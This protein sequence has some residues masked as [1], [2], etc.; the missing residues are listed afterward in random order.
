M[1]DK[2]YEYGIDKTTSAIISL[3]TKVIIVVIAVVCLYLGISY[4][5]RFGRSLLYVDPAE[6]TP[7][8]DVEI[9]ITEYDTYE[10]LAQKLYESNVITNELSFVVQG[11]L[12]DVELFPGTY[13]VNTSQSIRDI[14]LGIGEDAGVYESNAESQAA[15]EAMSETM[16]DVVTGGG[17]SD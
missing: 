4:G 2:Q 15:N 16:E 10:S 3:A 12:Y 5:F 1:S 13:T 17:E 7:G 6:E 8:R 9:T 14:L 11:T